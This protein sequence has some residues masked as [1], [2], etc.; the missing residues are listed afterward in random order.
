MNT[1]N[2]EMMT[3]YQNK[4]ML[5]LRAMGDMNVSAAQW[6]VNQ[7]IELGNKMMQVSMS[8]FEQLQSAKTP[9]AVLKTS[10][11]LAQT[12]AEE[13]TGFVK[14]ATAQA[15][16]TRDGFKVALEDASKLNA[17]YAEKA[18]KAGVEVANTTAQKVTKAAKKAA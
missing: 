8:S 9:E 4:A 11:E 12:V 16:E 13:L 18:L 5:S 10:S 3:E 17:E 1:Q 14:S 6:I 15:V 7:Q 2:I